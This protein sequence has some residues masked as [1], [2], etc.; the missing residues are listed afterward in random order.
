[1]GKQSQGLRR[2]VDR[3]RRDHTRPLDPYGSISLRSS[4]PRLE[5][6][7]AKLREQVED[8]KRQVASKLQ[9][10][11]DR[12]RKQLVESVLPGIKSAPPEALLS[13][14]VGR[15]TTDQLRRWV[16][17]QLS[18]FF[19]SSEK[20][21][22]DMEVNVSFKGVT[23]ETLNDPKFQEAVRKAFPLVDFDKPFKEFPA[24]RGDPQQE[25]PA[26]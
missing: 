11:L 13:S 18:H 1:M 26:L 10:E 15:P 4:R 25:I 14:I 3:I 6:A 5:K 9:K 16:E 17:D 8:F 21:V 20:L 22:A 12:S 23:Y 2:E 24:A 19:P 7:V